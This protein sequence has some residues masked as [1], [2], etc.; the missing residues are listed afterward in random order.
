MKTSIYTPEFKRRMDTFIKYSLLNEERSSYLNHM[1]YSNEQ[2]MQKI[3]KIES[4][5]L[6]IFFRKIYSI[7]LK[8]TSHIK[9]LKIFLEFYPVKNQIRNSDFDVINL[10][11]IKYD[12]RFQRPQHLA[13]ELAKKNHRIFYIDPDFIYY[14]DPKTELIPEIVKVKK[15]LYKVRLATHNKLTKRKFVYYGEISK[16]DIMELTD[17]LN[18][19]IKKT[20]ISNI[21]LK[22]DNPS[23]TPIIKKNK[24]YKILYDCLDDHAAL[25]VKADNVIFTEPD[26]IKKS[27]A[28]VACSPGLVKYIQK[29]TPLKV[30][31][32][33]NACEYEY[34][35]KKKYKVPEILKKIKHPILGYC[36]AISQRFDE[37]Y[38][39]MIAKVFPNYSIVLI[40]R[41]DK[42]EVKDLA[43]KFSNIYLL[44]EQDYSTLPAFYNHFDVCFSPYIVDSAAK[45]LDPVK[46]YEYLATGKPIVISN[47]SGLYHLKNMIYISKNM[48]DF[49]QNIRKA[50][51]ENNS[52]IIQKR[53][54]YAK[55]NTWKNRADIVEAVIKQTLNI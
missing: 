51:V 30:I 9:N 54:L 47:I 42:L 55:N 3:R 21:I 26:L 53:K 19:L 2:L 28:I 50:L 34:F 12:F 14:E 36:G 8:I 49:C 17:S 37:R 29:Q 33:G 1:E 23:W 10:S 38:I 41:L 5:S 16:K 48:Q 45:N 43:R 22:V 25:R 15:N 40:G 7:F 44:G 39:E 18:I 20:F 11:V 32:A 24:K 13:N 46:I 52:E 35:S 6:Y 31:L 4:N 27:D